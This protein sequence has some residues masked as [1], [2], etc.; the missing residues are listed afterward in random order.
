MKKDEK[1]QTDTNSYR[2]TDRQADTESYKRRVEKDEF[3]KYNFL[4]F[5]GF[6]W[7]HQVL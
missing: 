5:N 4:W 2:Q 3:L 6:F 7:L 1:R